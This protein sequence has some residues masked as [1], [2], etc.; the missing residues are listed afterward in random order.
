MPYI[1]AKP[2][3]SVTIDV[4]AV[5][6]P[7]ELIVWEAVWKSHTVEPSH[8]VVW[9]FVHDLYNVVEY[10]S[11]IIRSLQGAYCDVFQSLRYPSRA[12]SLRP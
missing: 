6:R 9:H 5:P 3:D 12:S 11:A 2:I 7:D 10:D 4:T 8:R 1:V